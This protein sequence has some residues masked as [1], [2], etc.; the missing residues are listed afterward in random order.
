VKD[1]NLYNEKNHR[2]VQTHNQSYSSSEK[3]KHNGNSLFR[4][5]LSIVTS[6]LFPPLF[7]ILH[8]L[9]VGQRQS[10]PGVRT[11]STVG[12]GGGQAALG[13]EGYTHLGN[14]VNVK[15]SCNAERFQGLLALESFC[16]LLCTLEK[17]KPVLAL[18]NLVSFGNSV[19]CSLFLCP[20]E[21]VEALLFATL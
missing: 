11:A 16:L 21:K 19:Q 1:I 2:T 4:V 6:W 14:Q 9:T 8:L 20:R 10:R 12:R 15:S 7:T 18:A 3:R 5:V 13:A 17:W